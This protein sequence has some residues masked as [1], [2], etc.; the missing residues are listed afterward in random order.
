MATRITENDIIR[1]MRE[2]A[3]A[4]G[5]PEPEQ[6][7]VKDSLHLDAA[8][9]GYRLVKYA[10]EGGGCYTVGNSGYN[11]KRD[12]YNEVINMTHGANAVK[13]KGANRE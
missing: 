5:W 12:V 6:Y 13:A 9:G 1:A 2:L 7:G 8:Y 4:L 10:G 3:E 11:P